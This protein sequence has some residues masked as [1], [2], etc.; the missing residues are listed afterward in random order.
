MSIVKSLK[1]KEE[2]R[3][4]E[5]QRHRGHRGREKQEEGVIVFHEIRSARYPHST[6]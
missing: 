6:E 4:D 5:S 2:G 1:K 3:S